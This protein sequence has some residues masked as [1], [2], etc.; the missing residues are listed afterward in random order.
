M[1]RRGEVSEGLTV[2]SATEENRLPL[3]PEAMLNLGFN[4]SICAS[5]V[6]PP[7]STNILNVW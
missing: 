5:A 3:E 2:M 4:F 7:V 1:L 6:H